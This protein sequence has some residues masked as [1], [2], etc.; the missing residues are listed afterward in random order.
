LHHCEPRQHMKVVDYS[1]ASRREIWRSSI[2][3]MRVTAGYKGR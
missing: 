2:T 1:N 3:S